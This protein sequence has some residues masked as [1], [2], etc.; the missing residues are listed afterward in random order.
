MTKG[1]LRKDNLG[2][3]GQRNID[4]IDTGQ[5]D[6]I[7]SNINEYMKYTPQQIRSAREAWIQQG[8]YGG[9]IIWTDANKYGQKREAKFLKWLQQSPTK[10]PPMGEGGINKSFGAFKKKLRDRNNKKYGSSYSLADAI[11]GPDAQES[12][13]G[14]YDI[15]LSKEK[16]LQLQK[17]QSIADEIN[18]T[19]KEFK[20]LTK[21]GL[22]AVSKNMGTATTIIANTTQN[23]NANTNVGGGGGSNGVVDMYN[24][25]TINGDV[26]G[27]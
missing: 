17:D 10:Y 20:E 8:G 7:N 12:M 24:Q 15:N 13:S 19:L 3:F 23:N 2:H 16:R 14:L 21:T 26:D 5:K 11:H 9:K 1:K 18:D 6:F 27:D 22:E 25:K 4:A